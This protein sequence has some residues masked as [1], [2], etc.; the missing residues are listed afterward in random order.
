MVHPRRSSIRFSAIDPIKTETQRIEFYRLRQ[1][2]GQG[3][4]AAAIY[5]TGATH[6]IAAPIQVPVLVERASQEHHIGKVIFV[7]LA[8]PGLVAEE[9]YS[10]LF[11][12]TF[13]DMQTGGSE[14]AEAFLNGNQVVGLIHQAVSQRALP[15]WPRI[16][17]TTGHLKNGNNQIK[18]ELLQV[19]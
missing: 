16:D 15:H 1:Y 11:G 5:V 3:L 6:A 17:L 8:T 2:I 12:W 7:E 13:R 19:F 10:G 14:Y 4:I 9:F 18:S